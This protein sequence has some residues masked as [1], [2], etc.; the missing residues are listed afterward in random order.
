MINHLLNLILGEESNNLTVTGTGSLRSVFPVTDLAVAVFGAVGAAV[1]DLLEASEHRSGEIA[2]DRHR[3]SAWF[4]SSIRPHGWSLPSAWDPLAGD[5]RTVDG[6]IRLHTN[7]PAHRR[8]ALSVLHVSDDPH[9]VSAAVGRWGGSEL[10]RA[11]IDGGGCAA[12]MQTR[13]QWESSVPG[14]SVASEPLIHWDH[15]GP[16]AFLPR[17]TDPSQPLATVRV[18][19][20]THVLAGPVA[21]RFLALMGADVLRIDPPW[22]EEPAL[23][24]DVMMGKRSTRLDLRTPGNREKFLTLLSGADV[25]VHG[26]RPGALHKLD[27]GHAVRQNTRPGLIE[28]GLNAY[29]WSGPWST[30][31]GFDSLV[32]MSTG[33][34]ETGMAVT[35]SE[36]PVPLPVQA[37]DHATGYLMAYATLRALTRVIQTGEG[38]CARVS[39]A[40]TARLLTEI[41]PR[42]VDGGMR[43][44]D[45]SD[46]ATGVELTS[47]G[48][49]RRIKPPLS[50]SGVCFQTRIPARA[51]G[52][53]TLTWRE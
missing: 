19:D 2:V 17:I 27:L 45:Q 35:R 37:I 30:R 50:V 34:A 4:A 7:V 26:Y 31:R 20:L 12:H 49:A 38:S 6:W 1:N 51:L 16:S 9:S 15:A 47:W 36:R 39:L 44:D 8:A 53:D 24:P 23:I 5:Y 46:L 32:Q 3:A 40:R 21:T 41:G 28:V 22:W 18:L 13:A 42:R 10:E 33:I 14:R 29:G 43:E 48:P 52:S 11:I 25:L